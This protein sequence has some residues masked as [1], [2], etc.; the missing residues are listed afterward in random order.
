MTSLFWVLKFLCIQSITTKDCPESLNKDNSF[1]PKCIAVQE[2]VYYRRHNNYYCKV[3]VI[4]MK[5]ILD[6]DPTT[7]LKVLCNPSLPMIRFGTIGGVQLS[8][9]FDTIIIICLIDFYTPLLYNSCARCE[10][11]RHRP[12]ASSRNNQYIA[13]YYYRIKDWKIK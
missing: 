4:K 8:I 7:V 12:G 10:T 1:S 5:T 6:V 11:T 9:I 13:Y 3:W 2:T